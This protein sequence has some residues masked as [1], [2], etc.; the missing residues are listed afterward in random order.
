MERSE[1]IAQLS[2]ALAKAQ[3]IMEPASK[4]ATNPHFGSNFAD[5]SEV[6]RVVRAAFAPHGLSVV[7]LPETRPESNVLTLTTILMHASGEWLSSTMAVMTEKQTAQGVGSGLTY[8]RRYALAALCGVAAE[9]DDDGNAASGGGNGQKPQATPASP[10]STAGVPTGMKAKILMQKLTNDGI[11]EAEVRSA[12]A[13]YRA[14]VNS[15]A[16]KLSELTAA[17]EELVCQRLRVWGAD[18]QTVEAGVDAGP[19]DG[20]PFGDESQY[21]GHE[22]DGG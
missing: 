12:A 22:Q 20:D 11:P 4:N 18:R 3:A 17:Q 16:S 21:A 5:L 15:S 14:E 13:N 6:W 1:S 19:V 7:Q 9:T 10:G 2:D 8:A